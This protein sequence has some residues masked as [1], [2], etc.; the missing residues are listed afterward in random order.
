MEESKEERLSFVYDF[1]N[2][3]NTNLPNGDFLRNMTP[4][5]SKLLENR[6]KEIIIPEQNPLYNKTYILG[7]YSISLHVNEILNKKIYIIG[8]YHGKTIGRSCDLLPDQYRNIDDPPTS[9][10][11]I[12]MEDFLEET[13]NN[14][15]VFIDFYLEWHKNRKA[16]SRSTT[17]GN[18]Y[19]KF[20]GCF[21]HG[22]NNTLNQNIH[23]CKLHRSHYVDTRF[24][25]KR[26]FAEKFGVLVIRMEESNHNQEDVQEIMVF[27]KKIYYLTMSADI[28]KKPVIDDYNIK[29]IIETI[30]ENNTEFAKIFNRGYLNE[31]FKKYLYYN[32][33]TS[34]YVKKF[35]D[36]IKIFCNGSQYGYRNFYHGGIMVGGYNGTDKGFTDLNLQE[37]YKFNTIV[38]SSDT[39]ALLKNIQKNLS[40]IDP[41]FMD[42]YTL[43]RIFKP[44]NEKLIYTDQPSNNNNVIIYVGD[45]HA[46]FY[47]LFLNEILGF[48]T[49]LYKRNNE[50]ITSR[51]FSYCFPLKNDTT[52]I[53]LPF[54]QNINYDSRSYNQELKT[55]LI[56]DND[57][58]LTDLLTSI[59]LYNED[60]SVCD[61]SNIIIPKYIVDYYFTDVV[62]IVD[63][64]YIKTMYGRLGITIDQDIQNN[65]L[66]MYT[67]FRQATPLG[68]LPTSVLTTPRAPAPAPAPVTLQFSKSRKSV[69][70]SRKSVSKSR[71]SVNKSRKSVN[72][73]RK[74]VNKSR[75]SVNKSR[76]SVNKSR[77]SVNKN[78]KSV[79]KNRKSVNK[80]RKSVNKS[81][82]SVNKSRKKN[83]NG[84]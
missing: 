17:L 33:K 64:Q 37:I 51:T 36:D 39:S 66:E 10:N 35:C 3:T 32:F 49:L 8:E 28:H 2:I 31:C 81:R 58:E 9:E 6:L 75:K 74:S 30:V 50:N 29:Y 13:F 61:R 43:Y 4:V 59:L 83:M 44:I 1:N 68:P 62:D 11:T 65:W 7:P 16:S 5:Q 71:K 79:N 46:T 26:A 54:F 55:L 76:K 20:Q 70:K 34:E 25:F 42:L 78:R 53:H 41:I 40:R 82:K 72:K 80:S 73:S 47:R 77:K 67:K 57:V 21:E 12:T 45:Y 14:T 60:S 18:I 48:K 69:N 84:I 56:N 38:C 27:I 19:R 52:E 22:K 63:M 24:F 23:L 15:S